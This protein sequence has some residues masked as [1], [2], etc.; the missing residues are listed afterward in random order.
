[1]LVIKALI[2]NL[3]LKKRKYYDEFKNFFC[4]NIEQKTNSQNKLEIIIKLIKKF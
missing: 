3:E 2:S 4:K 1:M